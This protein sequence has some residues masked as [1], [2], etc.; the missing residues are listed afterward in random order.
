MPLGMEGGLLRLRPGCARASLRMNG[1]R[2]GGLLRL[3]PGCA[4]ASL[5]MNGLREG[6]ARAQLRMSGLVRG[7]VPETQ[8][9]STP[10]SV[11]AYRGA[12]VCD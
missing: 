1:L 4:R 2:E 3:R 12:I 6:C 8:N 5:R 9:A 10:G 11:L 7:L